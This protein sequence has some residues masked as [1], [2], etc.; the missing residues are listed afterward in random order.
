MLLIIWAKNGNFF[1]KC[2]HLLYFDPNSPDYSG[3]IVD[4]MNKNSRNPANTRRSPNDGTMLANRPRRW[5]NIV[6]TLGERLVFA[7]NSM[8]P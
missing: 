4:L 5:P 2:T 7:G 3:R 1:Q 6:P 8:L